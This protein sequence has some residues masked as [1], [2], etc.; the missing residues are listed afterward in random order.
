VNNRNLLKGL[1]L[2]L[3]ATAFGLGSFS[4][5]IG[6][7]GRAGPGMFPMLVASICFSVGIAMVIQSRGVKPVPVQFN[8]KIKTS[9]SSSRRSADSRFCPST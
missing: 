8:I 1:F 9:R 2:M 4:Y 7:L 6:T 3:I 5:S